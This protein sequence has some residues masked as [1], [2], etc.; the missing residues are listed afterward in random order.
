MRPW[1]PVLALLAVTPAHAADQT[2]ASAPTVLHLS[3]SAER[4]ITRD[5][6]HADLRAEGKGADPRTVEA[7]INGT[8]AK[9]LT[10]AKRVPGIEVS[11]GGYSVYRDNAS[12][13]WTGS[14]SLFLSGTDSAALLSLA[15]TLQADGL[16]MSNLTYE[17]APATVRGAES[18]LTA[19]ALAELGERAAAVAQQLNLSVLG[20][21]NLTVGNAETAGGPMPRF[22]A[23]ATSAA[24]PAPVAAPGEGT[25]RVTV[26]A[27]VL[28]GAKKP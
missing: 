18:A 5:L 7:A 27:D 23:V 16:A 21:R 8:M 12:S 15:G 28:L 2:E 3:Q 4:R 19:E 6:L 1:L 9:A 25:V 20:Y 24:M 26:S 11:T 13:D 17:V 10:E 14:Q 22:A